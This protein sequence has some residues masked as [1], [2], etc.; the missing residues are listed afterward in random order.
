MIALSCRSDLRVRLEAFDSGAD[1]V[2]AI[3]FN[4]QELVARIRAI[5]RRTYRSSSHLPTAF[6]TGGL[7][8]D[9]L[10]HYVRVDG[11]Q[12]HLAPLDQDLLYLLAVNVGRVVSRDEILDQL[13]G[14][15]FVPDS[16][17]VDRHIRNLRAKLQ[18][19]WR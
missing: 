8:I 19:D 7:E 1:D 11:H 17:V 9:I 2:L 4:S 18:D 3:P 14:D 15:D 10:S 12:L 6:R 5:V 13:W 16:N